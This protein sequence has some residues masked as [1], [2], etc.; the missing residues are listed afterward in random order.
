M[1]KIIIEAG[2]HDQKWLDANSKGYKEY[3][4]YLDKEIKL[5]DVAKT[6]VF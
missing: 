6:T 2:L 4:A 1:A 3:K 5:D